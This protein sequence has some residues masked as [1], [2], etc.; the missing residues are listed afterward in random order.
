MELITKIV[1][2]VLTLNSTV[3]VA[4]MMIVLCLVFRGG[5]QTA[6]RSGLCF[7]AG[8]TGINTLMTMAIGSLEPIAQGI[9]A[10]LGISAS[11]I[12]LG[13][14]AG[15]M[16]VWPGMIFVILGIL[17]IDIILV[18]LKLSNTLWTDIHNMW[19]GQYVG[20]IAWACTG[21]VAIGVAAALAAM[22]ISLKL[23][24]YHARRF[25]EF[26]EIGN[27]TLIA[28]AA[29]LPATFSML[30]MKV[31]DKIPGLNTVNVDGD[32]LKDTFGV[33]GENLTI[34]AA[35]GIVLSLL[36]GIDLPTALYNGIVLGTTLGLF[37]RI[38]GLLVEG[39]VPL[40]SSISAFMKARFPGRELNI[41]VDGAVLLGNPA[42]MSTFVMM[43]P[44][45]VVLCMVVPG[46][47]FIP[48]ASLTALPYWIG[49]IVPY[50]K[51]NYI[52]TIL[53]TS[54]WIIV[55]SLIASAMAGTITATLGMVGF[56][57]EEIAAGSVFTCWDE[58]GNIFAW[59]IK[60]VTGFTG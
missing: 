34:G 2:A 6:L 3:F 23:A 58:G 18:S 22:V 20:A 36:A 32:E 13:Y 27:V 53:V 40:S 21:N 19:H 31:I 8:I 10:N 12:D 46:I 29:T 17:L 35:L 51:G 7:A 59:L 39:I 49:A 52:H 9:S 41:A 45:S 26:N 48:I 50:T 38:A 56:Y 30:C 24:D 57:T 1:T 47:H 54:L 44:I 37:P 42:V 16:T 15:N 5:F 33:F 11:Q 14:A 43:V 55:S 60:L 25:Q 28:T 4:L